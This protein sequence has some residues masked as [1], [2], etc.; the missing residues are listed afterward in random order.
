M[1]SI[2]DPCRAQP[3]VASF[4][5]IELFIFLDV[6]VG[7]ISQVLRLQVYTLSYF[8]MLGIKPRASSMLSKHCNP[9]H[10]V[11]PKLTW[12]LR[13]ATPSLKARGT[14]SELDSDEGLGSRSHML[15]R[16]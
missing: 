14:G 9:V 10:I 4:D 8:V 13:I 12:S 15:R 2:Q 6:P 1:Y 3:T 5:T 16:C 7:D 11:L